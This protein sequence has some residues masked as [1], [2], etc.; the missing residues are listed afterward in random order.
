V[1]RPARRGP[2][3]L[4]LAGLLVAAAAAP[5]A[6]Q[7][8]YGLRWYGEVC[9]PAPPRTLALGGL[10]SV[11]PWGDELAPAAPQN[12][13][14]AAFGDQVIFRIDWELGHLGG[15]YPDGTGSL[16]QTGPRGMGLTA[17]LGRGIS[18]LVGLRSLTLGE[19]EVHTDATVFDQVP[20]HMDYLGTGGLSAGS[21]GAAWRSRQGGLAV[22]AA[23]EFIFGALKQEWLTD[24]GPSG[25]LD[26]S[27]RL[28]RQHRGHRL[29]GGLQ[30]TPLAP[31][32]L[33]ASVTLPTTLDVDLI[34]ASRGVGSDTV[35]TRLELGGAFSVGAGLALGGLWSVYLD[36]RRE[37]WDGTRWDPAPVAPVGLGTSPGDVSVLRPEW[38]VGLGVERRARPLDEQVTLLDTLP[39]RAGLR[40]GRLCTPDLAGGA[41]ESWSVTLGTGFFMGRRHLAWG[42]L[43]LQLGRR[44]GTD[45]SAEGFWRIQIGLSGGEKWFQPP[46]R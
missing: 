46:Q 37:G 45:G 1:S 29:R 43:V 25:Y 14:L 13:A 40:W 3:C 34:Y 42:D 15:D 10:T 6:A 26:S 4:A 16:W 35:T 28:Q 18:V 38:S 32:R 30:I 24:F 9:T 27:D 7:T 17:P 11:L 21:A 44:T 23:V 20:V 31:L 2:T 36:G 39:L 41:V 8:A 5:A 33:G 22:G 19:F 12:P